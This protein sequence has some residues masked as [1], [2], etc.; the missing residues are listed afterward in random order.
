[1]ASDPSSPLLLSPA[2]LRTLEMR[3][4]IWLAPMCQYMV[5]EHDGVPPTGI[6]CTSAHERRA[7][8]A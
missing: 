8:S 3:N 4:R 1:M 2:R 7:A 5:E 6:S